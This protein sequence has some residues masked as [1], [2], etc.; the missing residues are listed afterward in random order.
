[1]D[2]HEYMRKMKENERLY[3]Y[4]DMS[5]EHVAHWTAWNGAKKG[6]WRPSGL[7]D[8]VLRGGEALMERAAEKLY[9]K[10]SGLGGDII[11][12]RHH[13][14]IGDETFPIIVGENPITVGKK[15]AEKT[16][17]PTNP[18]DTVGIKKAPFSTVSAPVMA[19][20]GVA[21]MEGALKYGRHNFRG[22]GVRASVYYDATIRHL[23]SYWEG[24][25]Q[26]PDSGMSH[27]TKAIASLMV[28]R[29]AMIQNKCDDD[30]P[31][32]SPEFYKELNTRA[33]ELLKRYGDV[34]PHHYT[35]KDDV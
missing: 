12:W 4:G 10:H 26:D 11:Y 1:M 20:V 27:V 29:D 14:E 23:F 18:K 19:E 28:L 24:E 13:Q 15:S 21:M 22:V 6:E 33:E 32:R 2:E 17:K 30:R 25:D 31:P 16:Q 7:V 8:V 34:N 5:E 3:M 35:I 9:W